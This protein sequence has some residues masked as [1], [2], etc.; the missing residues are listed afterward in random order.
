MSPLVLLLVLFLARAAAAPFPAPAVTSPWLFF[1]ANGSGPADAPP[2]LALAARHALAGYGWQANAAPSNYSH[3]EE[4]LL[5]AAR[6]LA[7]AAPALPIF[8]YRH[9]Q[10]AWRLFDVQRAAADGSDRSLFLRNFDGAPGAAECAQAVPG[11]GTSPLYAFSGASRGAGEFWVRRVVGELAAEPPLVAAVFFDECDWSACGY[12]F[13]RDGCANISDAFRAREL[14]AKLPFL[15]ATA[16]ALAKAGKWPIFS[17]K[18]LLAAAWAGLPDA[19]R[20]PCVQPHDAFAAALRGADYARFYEFWMGQGADLDAA[21]ITNALLEGGGGVGLVARA[22]AGADAQC[23]A[24]CE[25]GSV[26]PARLSYA[27]AAFLVARTSAWSYFGVSAGWYSPCW[28][29]HG[30]FDAAAKCG[31]PRAA[32]VRLSAHAWT[33]AYEGCTVSVNTSSAE[34]S[35]SFEKKKKC[36]SSRGVKL[37]RPN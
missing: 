25:Q 24:V 23:D 37:L 2:F 14:N 29:W 17:S 11:G 8:I 9:F 7:A 19:A 10:M 5:G 31:A 18:N 34:G 21:T 1:G 4:N 15:R 20:R 26:G 3:G 33:R 28:C 22:A 35:L 36:A 32:A 6:A 13:L 16:D 30:E 12:S 27:L